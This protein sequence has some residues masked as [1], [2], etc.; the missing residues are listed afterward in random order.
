MVPHLFFQIRSRI[1]VCF[2]VFC[3]LLPSFC[4]CCDFYLFWYG[5][6]VFGFQMYDC[7]LSHCIC[8]LAIGLYVYVHSYVHSLYSALCVVHFVR[9]CH[10]CTYSGH[11]VLTS[12][13]GPLILVPASHVLLSLLVICLSFLCM[14]CRTSHCSQDQH[15]P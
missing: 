10:L 7:F 15:V 6:H 12:G 11:C 5:I 2:A 9:I 4:L 8:L 14:F 13:I 3:F 1:P